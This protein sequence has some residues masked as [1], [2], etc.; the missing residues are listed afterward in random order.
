MFCV[1]LL[2]AQGCTASAP[3]HE[4]GASPGAASADDVVIRLIRNPPPPQNHTVLLPN[5]EGKTGRIT[6]RT[7]GGIQTISGPYQATNILSAKAPPSPPSHMSQEEVQ[8]IFGA[9]LSALPDK[10]LHILL[11]F[12]KG[13]TD[14]LPK[15][16]DLIPRIVLLITQRKSTDI[17][18]NGHTDRIGLPKRNLELSHERAETVRN[19]LAAQGIPGNNMDINYFGDKNLLTPEPPGKSEP[20]NRC[21][22]VIIR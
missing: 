22:E 6:V 19:L 1:L 18:I 5:A 3:S 7:A 9:A 13:S 12:K 10:S 4:S 11:Y 20:R 14:L 8:R 2:L 17:T 15:S 16:A 21:A